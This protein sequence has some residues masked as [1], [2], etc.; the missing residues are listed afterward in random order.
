MIGK[1]SYQ[2]LNKMRNE[3]ILNTEL[4]K[5][6]CD[7][8]EQWWVAKE[9][10]MEKTGAIGNFTDLSKRQIFNLVVLLRLYPK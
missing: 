8:R 4:I 3:D 9:N 10:E 7:N 1:S 5:N 6:L 2:A